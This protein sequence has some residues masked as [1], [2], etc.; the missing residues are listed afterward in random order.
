M[1]KVIAS[2]LLLLA[3]AL[4]ARPA[5]GAEIG[6]VKVHGFVSLGHLYSDEVNFLADTKEGTFEFNEIGL[7]FQSRPTDRLRLGVQLFSRDLGD[8]G[9]NNVQIDWAVAD[10]QAADEL[11]IRVGITKTP[12]GLAHDQIDLDMVRT[13]V[14]LPISVYNPLYRDVYMN[15]NG[16]NFY[17]RLPA[18]VLGSFEYSASA[19]NNS[20]FDPSVYEQFWADMGIGVEDAEIR[21]MYGGR[22]IWNTPLEDF[23]VGGS[24]FKLEDFKVTG[25]M[26]AQYTAP[27]PG[28]SGLSLYPAGTNLIVSADEGAIWHIFTQYNIDRLTVTGEV[29][30][31]IVDADVSADQDYNPAVAPPGFDGFGSDYTNYGGWYALLDY[32]FTDWFAGAI[33]YGAEYNHWDYPTGSNRDEEHWRGFRR[34]TTISARFNITSYWNLKIESHFMDGAA[35]LKDSF[36]EEP[37]DINRYW[38]LYAVKTTFYF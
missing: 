7:N 38:N 37:D 10:Y 23:R 5:S 27:I 30:R 25:N 1:K 3:A 28:A 19:G 32:Q 20:S 35:G 21:L 33:S 8:L 14:F 15:I 22:L 9:N 6:P 11:G 12:L 18:G 29:F 24:F 31:I 13:P 4:V 26:P 17:G 36:Q 2:C 34:D 16:A